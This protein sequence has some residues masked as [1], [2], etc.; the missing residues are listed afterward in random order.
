MSAAHQ[1]GNPYVT[2]LERAVLAEMVR[3]NTPITKDD[4]PYP[5]S[6]MPIVRAVIEAVRSHAEQEASAS[7]GVLDAEEK[8][9][10]RAVAAEALAERIAQAIEARADGS[11]VG[12]LEDL[13]YRDAARIARVHGGPERKA[14]GDAARRA[15]G[16]GPVRLCCGQRHYGVTCPDGLVMCCICFDRVSADRLNAT[17][18]GTLEDA[19][20][21]CAERER[22]HA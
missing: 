8:A 12:A 10:T 3:L 11:L 20:R 17:E 14:V 19:C 13:A 1:N 4:P 2:D 5:A 15:K 18:D 9:F 22:F 16:E 7:N 21:S 6:L